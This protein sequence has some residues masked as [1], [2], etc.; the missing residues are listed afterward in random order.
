[1]DK[2]TLSLK[3][4]GG[5]PS[6]SPHFCEFYHQ[7]LYQVLTVKNEGKTP[8]CFLQGEEEK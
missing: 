7:D 1:M 3:I 4:A 6:G 5:L 8:L 2:P